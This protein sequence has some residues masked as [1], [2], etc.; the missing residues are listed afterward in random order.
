MAWII[1]R[2]LYAYGYYTGGKYMLTSAR[3][4]HLR[5]IFFFTVYYGPCVHGPTE[6]REAIS[7][8]ELQ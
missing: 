7:P 1:G 4:I 8:L 3:E 2:V 6:G 5:F